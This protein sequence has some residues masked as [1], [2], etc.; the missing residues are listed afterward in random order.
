MRKLL[1]TIRCPE[2]GEQNQKNKKE[3][4]ELDANGTGY[5]NKC[6]HSWV[7]DPPRPDE[8]YS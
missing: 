1:A 3:M 6:S 8:K 7:A 2:C 5:C 4:I